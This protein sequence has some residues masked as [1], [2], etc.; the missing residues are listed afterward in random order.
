MKG[1][2]SDICLKIK[3]QIV[4]YPAYNVNLYLFYGSW[5]HKI[6][7]SEII[8]FMIRG[9]Q[10]A[11]ILLPSSQV[12]LDQCNGF[13]WIYVYS[14]LCDNSGRQSWRTHYF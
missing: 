4:F 11:R 13:G 2:E 1:L 9:K 12:S 7:E 14:Q 8:E 3:F 10:A 6:P 5:K